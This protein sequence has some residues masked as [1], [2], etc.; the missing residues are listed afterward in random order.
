MRSVAVVAHRGYSGACPENTAAAF[1]A[2]LRLGVEMIEF[3]VRLSADGGLAIVHDDTVDRTSDG[4]GPVAA[5]TI[6]ALKELDAGSWFGPQFAGERYLT[7][8]EALDLMPPT[9]RLNVHV[10]AGEQD[11][12]VVVPA[13]AGELVRRGLLDTAFVASDQQSL[14]VA[15]RAAPGLATCNLSVEPLAD[16]VA[17]SAA[18]GCRILQPGNAATTPE[19]CA[20]AHAAGLEV[21]PFFA[22]SRAEMRRL[23]G[24]GVD[25]ILTNQPERLQQLLVADAGEE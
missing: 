21:N 5:L 14:E 4:S 8:A 15:R 3:D 11:R 17:R 20:A 23:I 1:A 9:V 6:A 10:K 22:D 19:L 7:L 24:C 16:Y 12:H 2:A 25:G 18:S 13:V